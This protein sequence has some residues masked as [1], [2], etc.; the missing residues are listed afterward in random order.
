MKIVVNTTNGYKSNDAKEHTY[1]VYITY[2]KPSEASIAILAVDGKTVSN[3]CLRATYG[4]TKF[5]AFYLKGK[6][7]TNKECLYLHQE[8][9]DYDDIL[10]RDDINNKINFRQQ[11]LQAIKIA[12]IFNFEVRRKLI[13]CEKIINTVFPSVS[14]I[15]ENQIVYDSDI[16]HMEFQKWFQLKEKELINKPKENIIKPEL[17]DEKD[18]K[19]NKDNDNSFNQSL[20]DS[21]CSKEKSTKSLSSELKKDDDIS[22]NSV[23]SDSEIYDKCKN[24]P[25]FELNE[26]NLKASISTNADSQSHDCFNKDHRLYRTKTMSRFNFVEEVNSEVEVEVPNFVLQIINN[27]SIKPN[28]EFALMLQNKILNDLNDENQTYNKDNKNSENNIYNWT[29]FLLEFNKKD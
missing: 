11:Q 14:T 2:S 8:A 22:N 21:K 17:K 12:N 19:D 10:E 13:T 3:N 4:S 20:K 26:S 1:S 23:I 27:N 16:N 29:K 9:N 6:E 7:C 18:N 24:N 15:F 5:C 28:N 25:L